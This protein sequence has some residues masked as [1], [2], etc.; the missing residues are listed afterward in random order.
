MKTS[1]KR[2]GSSRVLAPHR[3]LGVVGDKSTP[4][5]L[6]SLGGEPFVTVS[7]GHAF[8]VFS[9]E[10]LRVEAVSQRMSKSISALAVLKDRTFVA[11]GKE[12]VAWER[13]HLLAPI[14]SHLGSIISLL[15]LGNTLISLCDQGYLKSW[16]LKHNSLIDRKHRQMNGD[17]ISQENSNLIE[18]TLEEGLNGGS[19]TVMIHP[20]TYVNKVLIGSSDGSLSLW[21]IR[22][23]KHLYSFKSI[24]TLK[25]K[26][27]VSITSMEQSP[28]LDVV[29]V[30]MQDGSVYLLNLKQDIVLF[31]LDTGKAA[32]T[33][34]SFR[35]DTGG[36]NPCPT[37]STGC[38]D[39]RI[40]I[41]DLEAR[42]LLGEVNSALGAHDGVVLSAAFLPQEPVLLTLGSDNALRSWIF[43]TNTVGNG[44][45]NSRLLRSREGHSLPPSMRAVRWYKGGGGGGGV[46]ATSGHGDDATALQLL[47]GS[48]DR[49]LRASHAVRD[50]L[51]C[52][53]SQGKVLSKAK[54]L[55]IPAKELKMRRVI[56]IASADA[57][58]RDWCDI[59][60][61]HENDS[62]VCIWRFDD[63]VLGPHELR[64]LHW[65][66]SNMG[67]D[68]DPQHYATSVAISVCGNYGIVGTQGGVIYRYNMQSG[69]P[70]GSYP[71]G[72][73]K[74]KQN[75]RKVESGDVRL[76]A[77]K[78][79]TWTDGPKGPLR[80]ASGQYVH[81][82]K[83]VG[84]GDLTNSNTTSSS[85]SISESEKAKFQ[86]GEIEWACSSD[87]KHDDAI[88]GLAL[89]SL[90]LILLSSSL[91]GTLRFWNFRNQSLSM[92]SIEN[93]S[94]DWA[95]QQVGSPI[96]MLELVRDAGLAAC[97]CDDRSVRVFDV[98]TRRLVRRLAAQESPFTDIAFSPDARRL[99]AG[100][101]D[102]S[103][104]VWDLPTNKCIDW[105]VFSKHSLNKKE[106]QNNKTNQDDDEDEDGL[107]PVTSVSVCPTGEFICTSH[108]G[109][110]GLHLWS[111]RTLYE[112]IRIEEAK[113]PMFLSAPEQLSEK[114]K[115]M[116]KDKNKKNNNKNSFSFWNKDDDIMV[117]EEKNEESSE[118]SSEENSDSEE[119]SGSDSEEAEEVEKKNESLGGGLTLSSLARSKWETLFHLDLIRTRNKPIE[120]VKPPPQAPFF[121]PTL[122]A[123][124]NGLTPT[125]GDGTTTFS[126]VG[127]ANKKPEEE[128]KDDDNWGAG[129]WSDDEDD[130]NSGGGGIL[131]KKTQDKDENDN[132]EE[133]EKSS[134]NV[135]AALTAAS[136]FDQEA[137]GRGM[138]LEAGGSRLLRR[139][140]PLE[141][142]RCQLA[143]MLIQRN[144]QKGD[145]DNENE[146]DEILI[147]M[148]SLSPSA[149]DAE[150]SRLCR[151]E[152]DDQPGVLLL[153]SFLKWIQY[154]SQSN[155]DFD[156]L[157]A[158]LHRFL[159]LHSEVIATCDNVELP[160]II[161]TLRDDH[162]KRS[163][164]LRE[165]VQQNLCLIN[166]FSNIESL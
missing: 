117:Q 30:G 146:N 136:V 88:T 114:N 68:Q 64:Q 158:Y 78:M 36:E 71:I 102:G 77:K 63:R 59:I 137:G 93:M 51:S 19:P 10:H 135:T 164:R 21:N 127:V 111:D 84:Y 105:A 108:A 11:C 16:D 91:D 61:A 115:T 13:M 130:A 57:R 53:L 156:L 18:M 99:Y 6:Q 80:N 106:N 12:I 60:T 26:S 92:G 28:A 62:C 37:L 96:S 103:L 48:E 3:V 118:E 107:G 112:S 144:D 90:N 56:A 151:D 149:V 123:S 8:Q 74:K 38:A 72:S 119:G 121:L 24:Q 4:F 166:F 162:T 100:G 159:M 161:H 139:T 40:W 49:S 45:A 129:A 122:R 85:L 17:L 157:Q 47:S 94:R 43:D 113:T 152:K 148:K 163:T 101:H 29:A 5:A 27:G 125:F 31:D 145:N 9:V 7:V 82:K 1:H 124:T 154:I 55:C 58:S 95:I 15:V 35:T 32:V 42:K 69:A 75:N 98:E 87:A 83:G 142:P 73:S 34:L 138:S 141:L 44:D 128:L 41:W 116:T 104:R 33:A 54:R 76:T 22:S 67:S 126:A 81:G 134:S 131:A 109:S 52:E 23:G 46:L 65:P 39:G 97:G 66:V 133:E 86:A 120:P 50:A 147:F 89:D 150:L 20:D 132:E 79:K 143:E 160:S 153:I 165:L 14:G 110:L 25:N 2:A 140:R 70:R 155:R